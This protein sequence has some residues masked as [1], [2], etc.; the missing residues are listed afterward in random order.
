MARAPETSRPSAALVRIVAVRA[1]QD[2]PAA[3]VASLEASDA[4]RDVLARHRAATSRWQETSDALTALKARIE[5]AVAAARIALDAAGA[6]AAGPEATA[7]AF[8]D[9]DALL[10]ERADMQ[11]DLAAVSAEI[12]AIEADGDALM[13]HVA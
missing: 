10:A 4:G 12:D 8:A 5:V 11:A 7:S 1:M 9:V 2:I 6:E 13:R 3:V